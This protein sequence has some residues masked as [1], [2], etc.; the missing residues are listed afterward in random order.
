MH[1][2][3]WIRCDVKML[4]WSND[5]NFFTIAAY[6]AKEG[7]ILQWENSEVFLFD[8]IAEDMSSLQIEASLAKDSSNIG[9]IVKI[10]LYLLQNPN[11]SLSRWAYQDYLWSRND[12][13]G[14]FWALVNL[15]FHVTFE[16]PCWLLGISFYFR[17]PN[18]WSAWHYIDSVLRVLMSNDGNGTMSEVATTTDCNL[19]SRFHI[20][21]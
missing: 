17:G 1:P 16:L 9:P 14:I 4:L 3:S 11:L 5:I 18:F 19:E 2:L 21:N 12:I 8:I 15:S 13:L 6:S 20:F 7:N 10:G